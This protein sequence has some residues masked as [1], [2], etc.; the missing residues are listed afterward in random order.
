MARACKRL[1]PKHI[2]T[3]SYTPRTNGKADLPWTHAYNWQRPHC[4][5]NANPPISRLGLAE[6][7]LL[8]LHT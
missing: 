8:T 2:R 1:G 6:D 5:V 4:S 3:R 7:N